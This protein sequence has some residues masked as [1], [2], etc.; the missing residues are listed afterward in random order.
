M[1]RKKRPF[2]KKGETLANT[3]T[4][5]DIGTTAVQDEA[6][7]R[8]LLYMLA[9][10][11]VVLLGLRLYAAQVVGFGD[12][13]ALYASYAMHP[14][15]TYRDHPGLVGLAMRALATGS[16]APSPAVVH[17][18]TTVSMAGFP[19][20]AVWTARLVGARRSRALGLGTALALAP[21][22]C[23]GLFA[24]TPDT[25]LGPM[26]LLCV[27]ALA[28]AL[29]K[30][31]TDAGRAAFV[32]AGLCAGVACAAKA[33]GMLLLVSLVITMAQRPA[34]KNLRSVYPWLGLAAAAGPLVPMVQNELQNGAPMLMH[35]FVHT[36][37]EAGLS[38]RNLLA[39]TFG[40]L[41]YA[42]PLLAILAA[43]AC[44]SAFRAHKPSTA[45]AALLR[46]TTLIPMAALIP[47]SLW[48]R[49]AEPHWLA[50]PLLC[51]GLWLAREGTPTPL[52]QR[53]RRAPFYL[54]G[55][56]SALAYAWVLIPTSAQLR[57]A[58]TQAQLDIA[59]ELFG[60][61]RAASAVGTRVSA[62]TLPGASLRDVVVVGPHW[63][64]C[65]Q[66]HA[67]LGPDV[68]VGCMTP[69][70]DDFETWLPRREW[71]KA[72]ALIYVTDNRFGPP[73]EGAFAG[74]AVAT[75]ET[76]P[77]ERGGR[78]IRTFEIST[79]LRRARASAAR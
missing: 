40:Q 26:W 17:I 51:A 39:V 10:V 33:T 58:S 71:E 45:V 18:T 75:T 59:S 66:L 23:V 69:I 67:A 61:P 16:G 57:P 2:P 63:T 46:N 41:L 48:S 60:W 28:H 11:T 74:H 1:A 36:Q 49:V 79:L 68:P 25:L 47:F 27:A 78:T 30:P 29:A 19:W 64:V 70:G 4:P 12:S 15:A 9:W 7:P 8:G 55:A 44:L 20:L 38:L 73:A 31:D 3:A 62:L 76:L 34:R 14:A 52:E 77:I 32:A 56:M 42:S 54:A 13:E 50:P 72:S 5:A 24:L 22:T 65:A 35:R 53:F 21:E 43:A 37:H 6:W